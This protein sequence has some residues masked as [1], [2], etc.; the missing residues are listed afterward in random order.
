MAKQSNTSFGE[1]I[2][3]CAM[4]QII[5][6]PW[7]LLGLYIWGLREPI[8][9]SLLVNLNIFGFEFISFFMSFFTFKEQV[10]WKLNRVW[11]SHVIS[12]TWSLKHHENPRSNAPEATSNHP[13]RHLNKFTEMS[14][15]PSW[16][17]LKLSGW[18]R[19][20]VFIVNLEWWLFFKLY[21]QCIFSSD[22]LQK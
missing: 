21:H 3:A 1:K 7:K 13:V 4:K 5:D 19:E 18:V 9:L 20:M 16:Q 2:L 15:D 17:A 10:S 6:F 8:F 11:F 22:V 12:T 14:T